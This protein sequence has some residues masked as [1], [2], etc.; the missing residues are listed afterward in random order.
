MV[1]AIAAILILGHGY[2]IAAQTEH[3]PFSFYPM[4]GR[5]QKKQRLT[6]LALYGVMQEGSRTRLE[7]IVSGDF[8]PPLSETRMRN[9]LMTS[10]GRDGSA[11]NA[12]RDTADILHDYLKRYEARRIQGLHDGPPMIEAQLCQ[13][14]YGIKPDA[15]SQKPRSIDPL[16]GVRLNG[17]LIKY[18]PRATAIA[19]K[20]DAIDSDFK[21]DAEVP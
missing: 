7:R 16:I 9:I 21:S 19:D 15:A 17:K 2:D 20:P 1:F 3:W 12:K 13:V 6:V 14:M 4:Y 18:A 5:V 11:K 8:V 10:W